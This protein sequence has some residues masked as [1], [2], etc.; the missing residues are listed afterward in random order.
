MIIDANTGKVLYA[1]FADAPRHPASLT[2]MMTLYLLFNEIEQGRLSPTSKI[3]ISERAASVA[4]S[5]LDL[6]PGEEIEVRDAIKALITKSAN[7]VA[8]AIAERIGGTEAAFARMMT[9]RARQMGMTGTTFVNASG[10]PDDQQITTARDMLTLALRLQ[11][12]FPAYYPLFSLQSFDF[13][14]KTYRTHNMLLRRVPGVD[15]IKTGYTRSSGFNLVSSVKTGK[16]HVVGAVFGG[17]TASARDTLMRQLLTRALAKASTERTRRPATLVASQRSREKGAPAKQV[18]AKASPRP[19]PKIEIVKTRAV[20]TGVPAPRPAEPRKDAIAEVIASAAPQNATRPE[21]ATAPAP[22]LDLDALREAMTEPTAD[23]GDAGEDAPSPVVAASA[24]GPQDIAG[25][26]R[27]SLVEPAAQPVA[28]MAAEAAPQ[29]GADARS[30]STLDRQAVAL[31]QTEAPPTGTVPALRP[32]L[33]ADGAPLSHLREPVA[34]PQFPTSPVGAGFE[35]QIGAYANA[36]DARSKLDL[37]RG[38]ASGLLNGHP[39]VARQVRRGERQ[40]FRAR[41]TG[42]SEDV[43]TSTCLE[44]R[45]LAIDCFVMKAE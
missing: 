14:G 15:G 27:R 39:G 40:I 42:F 18:A 22:R 9:E 7:D 31:A 23:Q 35:I 26:I 20:P 3:P 13:R 33:E 36:D 29:P 38:R 2:K 25:L 34:R 11:D 30:P 24:P 44:L 37:V 8:V 5:K 6:D 12:D 4:P 10:L 28:V 17:T 1:Q 32:T 41:F 21:A 19:E 43:G 16:K 45:R